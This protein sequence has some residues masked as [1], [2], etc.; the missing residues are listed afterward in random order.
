MASFDRS[1]NEPR[2]EVVHKYPIRR[3]EPSIKKF[4]K[5]LEI[6]LD[7]L[8]RHGINMQKVRETKPQP[9]IA[10]HSSPNLIMKQTRFKKNAI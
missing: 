5:V 1:E 9:G 3:L 6:D 4:L 2:C 7:R 10:A 8:H